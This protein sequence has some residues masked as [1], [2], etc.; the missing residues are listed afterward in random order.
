MKTDKRQMSLKMD[1]NPANE[2]VAKY[3]NELEYQIDI[4]QSKLD[5]LKPFR[6]GQSVSDPNALKF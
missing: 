6:S 2:A 3:C 5:F 4:M 1:G